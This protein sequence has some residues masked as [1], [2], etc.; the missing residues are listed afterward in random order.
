LEQ[1]KARSAGHN[2]DDIE[3]GA[4]ARTLWTPGALYRLAISCRAIPIAIQRGQT[5]DVPVSP[6]LAIKPE[7]VRGKPATSR[8]SYPD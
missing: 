3:G 2:P 8:R 6:M 7:H 5:G 1:T 4:P